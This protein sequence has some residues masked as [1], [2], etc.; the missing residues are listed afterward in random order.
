M[1]KRSEH[2]AS[3]T[4][5]VGGSS[6]TVF[7]ATTNKRHGNRNANSTGNRN[8]NNKRNVNSNGNSAGTRR[9]G[10]TIDVITAV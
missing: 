9:T 8:A 1:K 3:S 6:S 5:S 4:D 7:S 2:S 10:L